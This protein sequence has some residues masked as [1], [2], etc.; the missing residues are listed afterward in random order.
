MFSIHTRKWS[1]PTN[2]TD[3]HCNSGRHWCLLLGQLFI[4]KGISDRMQR[5]RTSLNSSDFVTY[6]KN[7]CSFTGMHTWNPMK[8]CK[9][10][11]N[12]QV[13]LR[14]RVCGSIVFVNFSCLFSWWNR[15]G[16]E[17]PYS[18]KNIQTLRH[19]T[20]NNK[21]NLFHKSTSLFQFMYTWSICYAEMWIPRCAFH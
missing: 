9:P 13:Y 7:S 1:L 12:T 20:E 17:D 18:Y 8:E 11:Y 6:P 10:I 14:F 5:C 2:A 21:V 16:F 4:V 19:F 3:N 15:E